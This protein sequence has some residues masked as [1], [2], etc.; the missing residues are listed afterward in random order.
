MVHT[1]NSSRVRFRFYRPEAKDVCLVG[2]FN[3]WRLGELPMER[4]AGGYWTAVLDLPVGVYRFRYFADGE[5]FCDFAAFGV[6]YGPFGP[7]GIIRISD[8]EKQPRPLPTR[9]EPSAGPHR[10]GLAGVP[11]RQG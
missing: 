3:G 1:L 9:P 5:W 8:A 6:E 10:A 7:D 11:A 4:S 2:D